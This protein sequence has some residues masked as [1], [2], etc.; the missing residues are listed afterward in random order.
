MPNERKQPLN[1]KKAIRNMRTTSS[2]GQMYMVNPDGSRAS[3]L[4]EYAKVPDKKGKKYA[5]YPSIAP[6]P[7]K[8]NS[9][10]P[11]DW[12]NQSGA[13]AEKRGEA[14][15]VRREKR[16]QKLSAGSWKKG[17]DRKDAMKAYREDKRA[18]RSTRK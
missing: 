15:F 8:E 7:G 11:E 14:V 12:T 17:Q 5:V 16:A 1:K 18:A 10:K 2:G 9:R 13:Q 4:M 6:K 3:H